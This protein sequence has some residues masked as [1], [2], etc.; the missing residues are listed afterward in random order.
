VLLLGGT[1]LLS[2]AYYD[3]GRDGGGN[4]MSEP[5]PEQKSVRQMSDEEIVQTFDRLVEA[6]E[7]REDTRARREAFDR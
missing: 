6:W 4:V 1:K 5:A 7:S 2:V 3:V